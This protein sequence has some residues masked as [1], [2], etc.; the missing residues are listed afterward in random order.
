M[1]ALREFYYK[2]KEK[3]CLYCWECPD[4]WCNTTNGVIPPYNPNCCCPNTCDDDSDDSGSDINLSASLS[5]VTNALEAICN[6]LGIITGETVQDLIVDTLCMV[7]CIS[8]KEFV[9]F[10]RYIDEYGNSVKDELADESLYTPVG[11]VKY[12]HEL[13][14][15]CTPAF[16]FTAITKSG[17]YEFDNCYN[18][19]TISNMANDCDI[20]VKLL[21]NAEG[22]K[23]Y[24]VRACLAKQLKF[25]CAF[26]TG[27][28]VEVSEDCDCLRYIDIDLSKTI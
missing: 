16:D 18:E 5:G 22:N 26:I 9:Y 21:G 14:N 15:K 1:F 23:T 11:T 10:T 4:D 17:I 3:G 27:I 13:E 20:I 6:K 28:E 2:E 12:C 19:I 7:D 8:S 25:D 24:V